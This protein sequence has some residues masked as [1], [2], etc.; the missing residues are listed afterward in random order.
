MTLKIKLHQNTL[1]NE[2]AVYEMATVARSSRMHI[3]IQVNPD[4]HH[5]GNPYF[6]IYNSE[7]Y[8]TAEGMNRISFNEPAYIQHTTYGKNRWYLNSKEKKNLISLLKAS[9]DHIDRRDTAREYSNWEWAIIQYNNEICAVGEK[10]TVAG[11][12]KG[13]ALSIDLPM[14]NYMELPS[15]N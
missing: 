11:R 7:S 3:L 13:N 5:I 1:Q 9:S 15:P 2:S 12:L 4:E 8:D 10:D 14:P 6:K